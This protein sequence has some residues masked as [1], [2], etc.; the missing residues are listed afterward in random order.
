M[1]KRKT[2]KIPTGKLV[3]MAE[4]V[5]KN[6]YTQFSNKVYKQISGREIGTQ[7]VPLYAYMFMDKWK[8]SSNR[9][10]SLNLFVEGTLELRPL[11]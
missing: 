6:N 10:K 3:N 11:S 2:H 5:L 1:D 8:V 9:R 7:S 4:F